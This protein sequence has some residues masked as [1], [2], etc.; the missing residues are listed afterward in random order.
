MLITATPN[1]DPKHET[2]AIYI[3]SIKTAKLPDVMIMNDLIQF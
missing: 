2:V 1:A 3:E